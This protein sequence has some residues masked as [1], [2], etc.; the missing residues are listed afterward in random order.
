ME[1]GEG[2]FGVHLQATD[3]GGSTGRTH[4]GQEVD[5]GV[6]HRRQH[7]WSRATPH[8]ATILPERDVAHVM[9]FVFD[10][11]VVTD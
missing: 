8:S 2:F 3:G 7:L 9:Q 1:K 11:P 6:A 4:I 5:D 10:A